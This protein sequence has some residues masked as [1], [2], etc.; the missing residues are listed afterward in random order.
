MAKRSSAEVKSRH[1][2]SHFLA[3]KL[4][5]NSGNGFRPVWIPDF[6]FD[7]QKH[8]VD[9]AVNQGR[10]A[11]F[12]DCGTG[13]TPMQLA[14]GE[15]VV[16]KTNRPVL[17]ITPLAVGAQT[18]K[19]AE[20]FGIEAHVSRDG[21]AHS[22]ITITNY[23]RLHH[24]NRDDFAGA[25]C[26]E[27]S[28][29]KSFDGKRRSV[30]TEFLRKMPYRL[31]CTATAAPNDY[32][33]LGTSSEALGELGYTDMLNRFFKNDQSNSA[34]GRMFGQ[35]RQWRFKGHAET[36]FWRW[37][38]SWARALRRPSDLGYSDDRFVLPPLIEKEHLVTARTLAP[39]LLF[40]VAK[41]GLGDVREE[42]R[43]TMQ[44]RC[45][46]AAELAGA[47]GPVV[48]W[49][50]LNPEGDLL[51]ELLPDCVQVSGADSLDRKE[52]VFTGFG[53]GEI[54][55]LITKAKIGA[56]GL[57]WQHCSHTVLFPTYSYEQYYQLVR[58]FWR[59]GQASDVKVDI[60]TTESGRDVMSALQRKAA[61]TDKM[62]SSL[63]SH[64]R[65]A[66]A[67]AGR[68]PI[69]GAMEVPSWL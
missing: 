36:P 22:G 8:L 64:M 63:V 12:A 43:R 67:P 66:Q 61:Q 41:P 69:T 30:V 11:I 56:W 24:F 21:R 32:I 35:G 26:D 51:A 58:R 42:Q 50:N 39:G 27:S 31:L 19:E 6:L 10:A 52:E 33:E 13:K 47:Q 5:A 62:F 54:R 57:N 7:F 23:E 48:V 4:H 37:V 28:A 3:G 29:I 45:E 68:L 9:W 59:F 14:W 34:T 44:E 17:I 25:I 16:R 20:K 46:R 49:C 1:N 65:Q 55:G 60:V 18:V 2:Y 15:N 40:E 53:K 38:S